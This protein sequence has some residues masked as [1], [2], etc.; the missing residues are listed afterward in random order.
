MLRPEDVV[1]K[2]DEVVESTEARIAAFTK[3]FYTKGCVDKEVGCNL[4]LLSELKT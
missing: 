2:D 1:E 4:T 3:T